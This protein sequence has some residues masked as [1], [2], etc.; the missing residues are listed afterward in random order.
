MP[1]RHIG[2]QETDVYIRSGRCDIPDELFQQLFVV[3]PDIFTLDF[4]DDDVLCAKI[5]LTL[6]AS[7]FMILIVLS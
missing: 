3:T 5:S 4:G 1:F 2:I 6:K 7:I